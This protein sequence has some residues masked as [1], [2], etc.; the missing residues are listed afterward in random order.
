MFIYLNLNDEQRLMQAFMKH[1]NHGKMETL[2]IRFITFH[3]RMLLQ[4]TQKQVS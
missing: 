2:K 3:D 1:N 4:G